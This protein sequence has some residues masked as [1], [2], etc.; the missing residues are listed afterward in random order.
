MYIVQVSMQYHC[1]MHGNL[2]SQLSLNE[3]STHIQALGWSKKGHSLLTM[4]VLNTLHC[5]ICYTA[6]LNSVTALLE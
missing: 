5:I 6:S 1:T 2:I 3:L 4:A